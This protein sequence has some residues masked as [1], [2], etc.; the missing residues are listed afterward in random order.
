MTM[1]MKGDEILSD[2]LGLLLP[3]DG[4]IWLGDE[5]LF[6]RLPKLHLRI[7]M[8]EDPQR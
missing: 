4:E 7:W 1:N 8:E 6:T 5:G 2:L 3:E